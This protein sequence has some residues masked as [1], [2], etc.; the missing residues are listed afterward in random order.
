MKIL[1]ACSL[2]ASSLAAAQPRVEFIGAASIGG[3]VRDRS[4][5]SKPIAEGTKYEVPHDLSGSMGSGLEWTGRGDEY[6]AL[7][8]RGPGD[9]IG[10]Y[11]CRVQRV[12]IS[13]EPG[14]AAP[15]KAELLA[16]IMLKDESGGPLI[17][18]QTDMLRRYD[19][20]G[21]RLGPGGV[22]YISEE[23]GPAIDAFHLDGARSLRLGVP[24]AFIPEHRSGNPLEELPPANTKGRQ[25]NRGFE[26]LA[27]SADGRLLY[28]APQSPLLQDGALNAEGKRFGV[29]VRFLELNTRTG[30]T[31]ELVYQIDDASHGISEVLWANE[32]T[33][34]VLERDGSDR[35]VRRIYAADFSA[36]TDVSGRERLPSLG[37]PPGV[38]VMEKRLLLDLM[39]PAWA[40]RLTTGVRGMPE[41]I[42]G[43]TFGPDLPDGRRTLILATDN[44]MRADEP[45]WFWA[46]ALPPAL[47]TPP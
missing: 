12:R 10:E 8:D 44:D 7:C 33:L 31:R 23:Y 46:F 42:E 13:I 37:L 4:G 29:S 47:L 14:S 16:T 5:L 15:L 11:H 26:G 35:R 21:I 18:L 1:F 3:N 17:G 24:A 39:D 2:I 27:I 22:L 30:A 28:A 20:E 38:K 6:L 43:L 19:P 32:R 36:A 45:T 40:D 41:K 25:P 9:G 34:L